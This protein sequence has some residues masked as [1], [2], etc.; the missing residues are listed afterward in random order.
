MKAMSSIFG[1]LPFCQTYL[2]DLL[3]HSKNL[4]THFEH[5]S[6]VFKRITENVISINFTKSNFATNQ[7]NYLGQI[8]S[9]FDVKPDTSRVPEFSKLR[10]K[11]KKE[12]QKTIG[13]I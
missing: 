4:Q 12:L 11:N 7:V 9:A 1:D 8:I 10:P 6:I 3:I 13:L 2:D 5:L